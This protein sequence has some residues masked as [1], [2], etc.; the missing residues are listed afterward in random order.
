[1]IAC[2]LLIGVPEHG[3]NQTEGFDFQKHEIFA[4]I[5]VD[6]GDVVIHVTV[7]EFHGGRQ[8]SADDVKIGDEDPG[9][10]D[11]HT[12][13]LTGRRRDGD[14]AGRCSFREFRSRESGPGY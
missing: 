9:G 6:H 5:D 8:V 14:H 10:I 7:G 4:F 13:T 11:D 3:W 2:L 12:G 1:M